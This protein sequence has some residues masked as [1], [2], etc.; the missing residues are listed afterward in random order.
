MGVLDTL[1]EYPRLVDS[2]LAVGLIAI[3]V[4]ISQVEQEADRPVSA[5]AYLLIVLLGVLLLFRREHAPLV[6]FLTVGVLILYYGMGHP[7]VGVD[8]PNIGIALPLAPALYSAAEFRGSRWP[9][10]AASSLI[11]LLV[12]TK[13]ASLPADDVVAQL[14]YK[15][16]PDVALMTAVIALGDSV[17]ARRVIRARAE[18][19][20]QATA[21]QERAQAK[22][23]AAEERTRIAQELHDALGHQ[24]TLIATHSDVAKEALRQNPETAEASLTIIGETSRRMMGDL[25]ETVRTLRDRHEKPARLT[26]QDVQNTL[27]DDAVINVIADIM[28]PPDVPEPV[29]AAAYRIVQEALNNVVKHSGATEARVEIRPRW[30]GEERDLEIIVR[31]SGPR[32]SAVT[33]RDSGFGLVGMAE[34]CHWLGGTLEAGPWGAGFRIRAL[35]PLAQVRVEAT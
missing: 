33:P 31:D 10:W 20:L 21:E 29:N 7:S 1:R 15:L 14:I 28:V 26:L 3:L 35:L 4:W 17:R 6:L 19:I 25:R 23:V 27:F 18:R 13:L 2:A 9:V 30:E 34:R 12:A 5:L 24:T 8:H 11:V 16:G 22:A 32:H